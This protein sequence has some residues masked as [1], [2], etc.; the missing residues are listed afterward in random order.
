MASSF[1]GGHP[2]TFR[3]QEFYFHPGLG[4]SEF[5]LA[6]I[7][8][9]SQL[10][11]DSQDPGDEPSTMLAICKMDGTSQKDVDDPEN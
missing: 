11:R 8:S 1:E 4:K 9:S 6:R 3:A 7:M 5:W 2:P 10:K